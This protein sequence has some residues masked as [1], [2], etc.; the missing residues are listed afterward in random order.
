MLADQNHERQLW[1]HG[2]IWFWKR[3]APFGLRTSKQLGHMNTAFSIRAYAVVVALV[4]QVTVPL[5]QCEAMRSRPSSICPTSFGRQI[6]RPSRIAQGRWVEGTYR[7]PALGY[8]IDIP[9]GLKGRTGDQSGPERG[10]QITLPSGGKIVVYA[11]PN[12]LEWKSPA[13]AVSYYLDLNKC[14]AGRSNVSVVRVG[15]LSGAEG[16]L[17]CATRLIKIMIAFHEPTDL[18]YVLRLDTV[19]AHADADVATLSRLASSLRMIRRE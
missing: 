15:R 7:N 16:T 10:F 3:R 14:P 11:Q 4:P 17:T 8:A 1:L 2:R 6:P 9:R 5:S 13:E 18:V 12:S 19:T